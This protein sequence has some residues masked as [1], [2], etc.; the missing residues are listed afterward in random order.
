[1]TCIVYSDGPQIWRNKRCQQHRTDGPA[2]IWGD[3]TQHWYRNDKL[4][5]TDG[6]AYIGADGSQCWFVNN[7]DITNE[8]VEWML[9]QDVT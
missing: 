5:R 6:P 9:S 4:H 2:V 8:V 1:M 7:Q 3:G